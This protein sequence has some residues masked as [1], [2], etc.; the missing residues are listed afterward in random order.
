MKKNLV[1]ILYFIPL[2]FLSACGMSFG[3]D[4][5][6]DYEEPYEWAEAS[7]D[8]VFVSGEP[9]RIQINVGAQRERQSSPTPLFPCSIVIQSPLWEYTLVQQGEKVRLN[10]DLLDRYAE[11]DVEYQVPGVP[12][13]LFAVW[14]FPP[15]RVES[16]QNFT[17]VTITDERLT[18]R[19]ECRQ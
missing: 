2:F 18:L 17:T 7:A 15:Y 16:I 10:G 8:I 6:V 11:L 1:K 14:A 9:P 3:A 13:E 19:N 12:S 5:N 4:D